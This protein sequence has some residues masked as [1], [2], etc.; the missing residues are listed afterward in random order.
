MRSVLAV[1]VAVVWLILVTLI[2]AN[3]EPIRLPP[4]GRTAP[5]IIE[6]PSRQGANK[7]REVLI[8]WHSLVDT[9]RD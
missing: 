9:N 1:V 6:R 8:D 5:S 7:D 3:T 2:L 4:D